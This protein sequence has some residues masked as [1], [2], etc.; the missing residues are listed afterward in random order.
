MDLEHASDRRSGH[1]R[2]F[3]G[4]QW[5]LADAGRSCAEEQL[6]APNPSGRPDR[7]SA[8]GPAAACPANRRKVHRVRKGGERVVVEH[9]KAKPMAQLSSAP[10]TFTASSAVRRFIT[11]RVERTVELTESRGTVRASVA[12]SYE[13]GTFIVTPAPGFL[14]VNATRTSSRR[15][16]GTSANDTH[17]SPSRSPESTQNTSCAMTSMIFRPSRHMCAD[18]WS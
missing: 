15:C 2:R 4:E 18:G 7:Y 6:R 14:Q 5:P 12:A 17:Q 9:E 3:A 16:D 8:P 10:T 13:M 1:A 11:D